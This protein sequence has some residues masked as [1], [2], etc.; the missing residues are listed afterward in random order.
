MSTTGRRSWFSLLI[1]FPFSAS[2]SSFA[3]CSCL[4]STLPAP[5]HSLPLCD[6]DGAL[7][8]TCCATQLR[9]YKSG[10][11]HADWRAVSWSVVTILVVIQWERCRF[12]FKG[13][14]ILLI[15]RHRLDLRHFARRARLFPM[16]KTFGPCSGMCSLHW[17]VLS[18]YEWLS[19][20]WNN[21]WL[22]IFQCVFEWCFFTLSP[23]R[24]VRT[25]W[26][27]FS[28]SAR[29]DA[30][31]SNNLYV[32]VLLPSGTSMFQGIVGVYDESAFRWHHHSD[33]VEFSDNFNTGAVDC[34]G[35]GSSSSFATVVGTEDFWIFINVS[36]ARPGIRSLHP[37]E[38]AR[39]FFV[40]SNGAYR[41]RA[42][43]SIAFGPKRLRLHGSIALAKFHCSMGL[44][45]PRFLF[46]E[47]H[48]AWR[49]Q[50]QDCVRQCSPLLWRRY[51]LAQEKYVSVVL[52]G[53]RPRPQGMRSAWRRKV[54]LWIQDQAGVPR[55]KHHHSRRTFPLR[56]VSSRI[57][58]YSLSRHREVWRRDLACSSG[59][60]SVKTVHKENG[61]ELQ[62]KW[63]WHVQKANTQSSD[64]RVHCP[65]ECLRAKVVENCRYTIAP[66]RERL[67]LFFA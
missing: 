6:L 63:C 10:W 62:S 20:R 29:C 60:L 19:V 12:S 55:Q 11:V 13:W 44:R 30:H 49:S 28:H 21:G 9:T 54:Q 16:C 45:I 38:C 7:I 32:N 8:T 51:S 48:E 65:E 46:P 67:K 18:V 56:N 14:D 33:G 22:H 40:L 36:R 25:T 53:A 37:P 39:R 3:L 64:P 57:L 5:A 42:R 24:G 26:H 52:S 2:V 31:T 66:T 34:C 17:Y 1:V 4:G 61:T 47:R 58:R 43:W 35:S 27:R 23:S 15:P 59:T 41:F 50:L